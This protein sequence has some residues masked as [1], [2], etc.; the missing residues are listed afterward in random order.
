MKLIPVKTMEEALLLY[1]AGLL[2]WYDA[3]VWGGSYSAPSEY[4]FSRDINATYPAD[5][6]LAVE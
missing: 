5:N 4:V 3:Q 6:Y 1:D 2:R